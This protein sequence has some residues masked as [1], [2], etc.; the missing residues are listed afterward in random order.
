[1]ITAL[2]K[3]LDLE[4]EVLGGS[5]GLEHFG[6]GE[7]ISSFSPVD[8]KT[9]GHVSSITVKEYERCIDQAHE[10]FLAFRKI[11]LTPLY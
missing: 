2:L 10:A 4:A 9:I 1:M 5:T 8:G 3:E 6:S 7:S 11:L